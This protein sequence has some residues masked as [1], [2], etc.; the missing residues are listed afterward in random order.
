MTESNLSDVSLSALR[1]GEPTEWIV[2]CRLS[3]PCC[4]DHD[5][6]SDPHDHIV[7]PPGVSPGLDEP[8]DEWR[9]RLVP[10]DPHRCPF[11]LE[12]VA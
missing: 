6:T 11:C 12:K 1:R 10:E 3:A 9:V 5:H 4:D 2:A 8:V 7:A